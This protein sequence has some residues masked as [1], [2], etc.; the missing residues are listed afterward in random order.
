MNNIRKS[1]AEKLN[2]AIKEY[3]EKSGKELYQELPATL[4][5]NIKEASFKKNLSRMDDNKLLSDSI[6]LYHILKIVGRKFESLF[7]ENTTES[8]MA[9][10]MNK[11]NENLL[12]LRRALEQKAQA[13][14]LADS[15]KNTKTSLIKKLDR[16][17]SIT[18]LLEMCLKRNPYNESSSQ[19]YKSYFFNCYTQTLYLNENSTYLQLIQKCQTLFNSQSQDIFREIFLLVYENYGNRKYSAL[20]RLFL[21]LKANK[22]NNIN[23]QT[24]GQFGI[25]YLL[26]T[27][28]YDYFQGFYPNSPFFGEENECETIKTDIKSLLTEYDKTLNFIKTRAVLNPV[29]PREHIKLGLEALWNTIDYINDLVSLHIPIWIN[30]KYAEENNLIGMPKKYQDEEIIKVCKEIQ[31]YDLNKDN[32]CKNLVNYFRNNIYGLQY[33]TPMSKRQFEREISKNLLKRKL[34]LPNNDKRISFKARTKGYLGNLKQAYSM[35][36]SI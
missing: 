27:L 22:Q 14:N 25:N 7:E 21:D 31:K 23:I 24:L 2:K 3:E 35:R 36:D 8:Q 18:Y 15:K 32:D 33:Q 30:Y 4:K 34:S 10:Y 12:E 5:E 20:E 29:L 13:L 6:L 11:I 26:V 9:F 1:P 16:L 17:F 28:T 19:N